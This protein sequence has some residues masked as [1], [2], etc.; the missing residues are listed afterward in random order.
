VG[1]GKRTLVL[2]WLGVLASGDN[3]LCSTLRNR[4]ETAFGFVRPITADTRDGLVSGT[5][6]EQ[7]PQYWCTAPVALSVTSMARISSV[8]SSIPRW[9]LHHCRR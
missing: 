8:A 7:A 5:L 1:L 3:G 9:A 6:V 2:P 4:F